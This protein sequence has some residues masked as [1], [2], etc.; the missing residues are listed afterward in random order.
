MTF[1][2]PLL[3]N[4][5]D[6]M[7]FNFKRNRQITSFCETPQ[8]DSSDT[9]PSML[10]EDSLQ[11][12]RTCQSSLIF[13]GRQ[14]FQF[15][16]GAAGKI[17]KSTQTSIL[18]QQ[19]PQKILESSQVEQRRPEVNSNHVSHNRERSFPP[20]PPPPRESPHSVRFSPSTNK[21][22]AENQKVGPCQFPVVPKSNQKIPFCSR[23]HS[24]EA[25]PTEAHSCGHK[26]LH[27]FQEL[28]SF[29]P[30]RSS[31][32]IAN[33][34]L[35]ILPNLLGIDE[36]INSTC[37]C[38]G[39]VVPQKISTAGSYLTLQTRR[40]TKKSSFPPG[41][42][43]LRRADQGQLNKSHSSERRPP[44]RVRIEESFKGDDEDDDVV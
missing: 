22:S 37:S 12:Q 13:S 32:F 14:K 17:K 28:L 27:D 25:H 35:S 43:T 3:N 2:E 18:K 15:P 39:H 26:H 30:R 9:K 44:K 23:G 19:L 16:P 10:S 8:K 41:H 38:S 24:T 5:N 6:R 31:S 7:N 33:R 29:P 11:Q 42:S 4:N 20:P 40:N 21:T 34:S 1:Y 36:A